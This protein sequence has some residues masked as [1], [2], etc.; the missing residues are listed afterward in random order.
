MPGTLPHPEAAIE[1]VVE[2]RLPA[3]LEPICALLGVQ[4]LLGIFSS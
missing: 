3:D 4:L 2:P 1:R